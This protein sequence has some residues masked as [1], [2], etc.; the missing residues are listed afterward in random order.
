[1]PIVE[2]RRLARALY[3]LNLQ[4][5]VPEADYAEVARV[6]VWVQLARRGAGAGGAAA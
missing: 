3:E 1:V 5:P 4:Q 6:L 2:N